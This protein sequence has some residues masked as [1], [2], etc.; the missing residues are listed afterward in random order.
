MRIFGI[1]GAFFGML[2]VILGAFGAHGLKGLLPS[3]MLHI[4]QTGVHYQAIHSLLLLVIVLLHTKIIKKAK[5]LLYSGWLLIYGIIIFSGS[6]YALSLTG[7]GI[8]GVVTPVGGLCFIAAWFLLMLA[9]V[10]ETDSSV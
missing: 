1:S 3:Q 5:L 10:G 9:F 4:F 6:L 7:I 8:F 2:S